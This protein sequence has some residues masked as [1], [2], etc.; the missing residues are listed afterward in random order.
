MSDNLSITDS[1]I[2]VEHLLEKI[3]NAANNQRTFDSA[4]YQLKSTTSLPS[5][6]NE[7]EQL[8]TS[9]ATSIE[10]NE[11]SDEYCVTTQIIDSCI[12]TDSNHLEIIPVTS[13]LHH[14]YLV[15]DMG[16]I[17][18]RNGISNNNDA[19]YI[20]D[21]EYDHDQS[22]NNILQIDIE[23]FCDVCNSPQTV[24]KECT[25]CG[26]IHSINPKVLTI[27]VKEDGNI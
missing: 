19:D 10:S 5:Y 27:P 3:P 6:Y 16:Y 21:K 2:T 20:S 11:E 17:A 24:S 25:A 22:F 9:A 7:V 13:R 18:D 15:N 12:N 1:V 23:D 8:K 26:Y 14:T 4:H